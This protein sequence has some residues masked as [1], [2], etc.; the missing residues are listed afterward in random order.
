MGKI[1]EAGVVHG[2]L[3]GNILVREDDS[4]FIVGFGLAE[5]NPTDEQKSTEKD[6][7]DW[8]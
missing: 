6:I 4:V 8:V 2:Y 5:L 3:Y 1:H 7:V